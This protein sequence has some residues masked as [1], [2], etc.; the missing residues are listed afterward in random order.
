VKQFVRLQTDGRC[1]DTKC[2]FGCPVSNGHS[3]RATGVAFMK[4]SASPLLTFKHTRLILTK[5]GLELFQG[6]HGDVLKRNK[7]RS[8]FTV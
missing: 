7:R 3:R 5:F 6:N 8:S 1:C 4:I 2:V